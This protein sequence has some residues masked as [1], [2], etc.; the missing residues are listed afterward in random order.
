MKA[1]AFAVGAIVLTTPLAY[2][3][4]ASGGVGAVQD[5]STPSVGSAPRDTFL[6]DMR[7]SGVTASDDQLVRNAQDACRELGDGFPPS[8]VTH[9][10]T[11]GALALSEAEAKT[12]VSSAVAAFCPEYGRKIR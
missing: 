2:L 8:V 12:L 1:S 5:G 3:G 10:M 4:C 11:V 7:R 6:S 9:D